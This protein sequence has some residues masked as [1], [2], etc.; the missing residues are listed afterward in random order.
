MAGRKKREAAIRAGYTE[1]S[2]STQA[3]KLLKKE[4]VKAHLKR[5][6][7]E[8]DQIS[9]VNAS[10]VLIE[11]AKTAFFDA[12]EIPKLFEDGIDNSDNWSVEAR[13]AIQG[14][15]VTQTHHG[16][17]Q[18]PVVNVTTKFKFASRLQALKMLGDSTGAFTELNVAIA[19]LKTYGIELAR[20]DGKWQVIHD[21]SSKAVTA[22]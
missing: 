4:S 1:A 3:S 15:E 9:S 22:A 19:A 18:D 2:A 12:S 11:L 16:T 13:S 6:R 10:R 5:L 7:A 14:I 17:A 8:Q 20:V 21:D